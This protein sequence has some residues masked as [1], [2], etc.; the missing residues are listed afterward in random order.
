M[1]DL[2]LFEAL[3]FIRAVDVGSFE[4]VSPESAGALAVTSLEA[5]TLLVLVRRR[6]GVDPKSRT[7]LKECEEIRTLGQIQDLI[8]RRRAE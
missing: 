5:V 8:D 1:T 6:T 2:G 3:A 7:V 4:R